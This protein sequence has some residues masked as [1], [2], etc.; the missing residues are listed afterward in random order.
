[1]SRKDRHGKH[2]GPWDEIHKEGFWRQLLG[3]AGK[4][5]RGESQSSP[6]PT[7]PAR[8]FGISKK[9][10]RKP[11]RG[12][13]GPWSRP[14]TP[15]KPTKSRWPKPIIPKGGMKDPPKDNPFKG[16]DPWSK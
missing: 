12:D 7:K 13:M 6:W 16:K 9:G 4:A 14:K 2:E 11:P 8:G 3:G 1:M 10:W 5:P 15:I